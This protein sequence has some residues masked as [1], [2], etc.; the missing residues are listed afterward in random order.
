MCKM[1]CW[2]EFLPE[3]TG[4]SVVPSHQPS[5]ST[6]HAAPHGEAGRPTS[7]LKCRLSVLGLKERV[8]PPH[9]SCWRAGKLVVQSPQSAF[10]QE[11][12][13]VGEQHVA[14]ISALLGLQCFWCNSASKSG[15]SAARFRPQG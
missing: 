3:K 13:S 2:T 1:R 15:R 14:W 11:Q 12:H 7:Y 8:C 6:I 10:R 5:W 4:G 9:C